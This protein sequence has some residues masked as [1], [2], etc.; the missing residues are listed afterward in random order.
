M[1]LLGVGEKQTA[2]ARDV[3]P[4]Q[5]PLLKSLN[6]KSVCRVKPIEIESMDHRDLQMLAL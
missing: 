2:E 4:P 5:L 1:A 3:Q 6:L